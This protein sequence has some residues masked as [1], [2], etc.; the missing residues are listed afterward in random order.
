AMPPQKV[1]VA[2]RGE[3]AVRVIRTCRE[4]G[5]PVVAVYSEVDRDALHVELADEARLLGA[6]PPSESYLNV[7]AILDAARSSG[8]TL[9]HPGYGFLAENADFARAV[10]EAG[11][12]FVGPPPEAMEMMGDKAAA[13]RAADRVGVPIVPG[14]S[15]P[16]G[17]DQAIREA[18]RIG[19]PVAVKAAFGGGGKGMRVVSSMDELGEALE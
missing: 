14:T 18:E 1:L 19:L 8:A 3:I 17:V 12:A 2:N 16:V 7:R 6:A 9:V 11:H 13:R 4:L 10:A 5:L 15:E